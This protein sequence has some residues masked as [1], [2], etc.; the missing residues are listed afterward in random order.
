MVKIKYIAAFGIFGI[1]T[2][3][4][5]VIGIL[6]QLADYYKITIDVAG[7]LLSLFALVIALCGPWITLFTSHYDRKK[8]MMLALLLFFISNVVSSVA[9]TFNLQLLA[10]ILPAFLHPVYF[11][12]AIAVAIQSVPKENA[13]KA[14]AI[15]FSGI[16]LA[17]VFGVPL[18]A[19]IT[20]VFSWQVSFVASGLF[21]LVACLAVWRFIPNTPVIEKITVLNQLGVLKKT[22]F[23]LSLITACLLIA[24]MFASYGYFADYMEKVFHLNG[25]QISI[26]LMLFGISGV[27]GNWIAGRLLSKNVTATVIAFAC[28]LIFI[29]LM[30]S[31]IKGYSL[32]LILLISVWGFVHTACFLIAQVYINS[33]ASVGKEF[34]NS[35]GISS[36]NLGLM[37]GTLVSGWIITKSGIVFTVWVSIAFAVAALSVSLIKTYIESRAMPIVSPLPTKS[38]AD[39]ECHLKKQ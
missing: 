5:G 35:L 9:P 37:I 20:E 10:R 29:F 24:S 34:A 15:V 36:G 28:T 32:N 33:A 25:K 7:L 18:I 17:T 13:N 38:L 31:L 19:Y 3:E 11:A 12:S 30:L 39:L 22:T 21:N 1:I 16:S 14:V 27:A 26:L 4:F 6:P 23:I 2:T 8:M